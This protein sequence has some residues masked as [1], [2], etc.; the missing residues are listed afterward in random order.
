MPPPRAFAVCVRRHLDDS[1]TECGR[2]KRVEDG[3]AEYTWHILPRILFE[4]LEVGEFYNK[5]WIYYTA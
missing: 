1:Q 5:T 3:A 2:E 4:D